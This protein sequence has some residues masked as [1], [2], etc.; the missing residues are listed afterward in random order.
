MHTASLGRRDG[1]ISAQVTFRREIDTV[2]SAEISPSGHTNDA[3][4]SFSYKNLSETATSNSAVKRIG[5]SARWAD[6]PIPLVVKANSMNAG[7]LKT[8]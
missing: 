4:Y 3:I 8:C 5:E 7:K 1:L 6:L 2:M